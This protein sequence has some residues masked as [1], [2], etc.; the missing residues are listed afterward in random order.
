MEAL[1]TNTRISLSKILVTTDFSQVSKTALAYASALAGQYEAKI[2][3]AH[4]LSPEPMLSVPLDPLPVEEDPVRLAA[5]AKLVRAA[6]E[7]PTSVPK[8]RASETGMRLLSRHS[9][10]RS[11]TL[12]S[13]I[14]LPCLSA[15][16]FTSTPSTRVP[17]RLP[18]S[19][20][21]TWT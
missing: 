7:P 17:F 15:A 3:V 2:T 5:E 18:R 10:K 13:L 4:A 11:V 21:Q 9:S 20:S 6:M 12:P 1:G 16:S 19:L 14:R 8:L